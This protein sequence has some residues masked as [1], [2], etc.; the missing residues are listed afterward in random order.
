M[1]LMTLTIDEQNMKRLLK[2]ALL[3][4]FEER[5]ELF[6][7]LVSEV[8]EDAGLIQAIKEGKDTKYASR[9]EVFAI[10]DDNS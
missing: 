6:Y 10:L 9:D 7:E 2:E 8:I 5:Q 4:L 1:T 3:E